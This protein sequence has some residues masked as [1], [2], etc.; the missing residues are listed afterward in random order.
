MATAVGVEAEVVEML[1]TSD[2]QT[3][4]VEKVAAA[5]TAAAAEKATA[6]ELV[7]RHVGR[8]TPSDLYPTSSPPSSGRPRQCEDIP[9]PDVP[10]NALQE[11][12]DWNEFLM[13]VEEGVPA[14]VATF[15]CSTVT[16]LLG[17]SQLHASATHTK[18]KV[19]TREACLK[20]FWELYST[21]G[22][23][24]RTPPTDTLEQ[25]R[26]LCNKLGLYHVKSH[27]SVV[28]I[29]AGPQ[30]VHVLDFQIP[31]HSPWSS[32]A[33]SSRGVGRSKKDV[34]NDAA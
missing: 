34:H 21:I 15:F 5:E 27:R 20:A 23:L 18:K 4:A 11:L 7:Q 8:K 10:R 19:A 13:T 25:L 12:C 29:S 2:A 31:G 9:E 6:D 33:V 3:A 1:V 28:S 26:T 24:S 32:G 17:D 22:T 16:V 30:D 14:A